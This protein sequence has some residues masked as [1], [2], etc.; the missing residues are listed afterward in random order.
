MSGFWILLILGVLGLIVRSILKG[1]DEKREQEEAARK[2]EAR[3]ARNKARIK[4]LVEIFM[5]EDAEDEEIQKQL[6]NPKAKGIYLDCKVAGVTFGRRQSKIVKIQDCIDDPTKDYHIG[7]SLD[8]EPDNEHDPNAIRVLAWAEYEK[9]N[10]RTFDSKT[11]E[12]SIGHIGYIP[13]E[14][15]AKLAP[16]MNSDNWSVMADFDS[17]SEFENEK[18]KPIIAVKIKVNIEPR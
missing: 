15:A 4:D 10:E 5:S 17:I 14:I 18:G 8:R 2:N 6:L 7:I 11:I 1:I 9:Y 3:E 16:M 12:K 13:A